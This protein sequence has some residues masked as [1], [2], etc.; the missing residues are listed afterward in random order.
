MSPRRCAL[1][2]VAALCAVAGT[3]GAPAAR[4][5]SKPT[6]CVALVV[7]GRALGS[8]V[9]TGCAKVS[10]GATGVA[11]L[12]AAD[13]RIGFRDDGL[14]CTID[15]LPKTGCASVDDTHYWAYF[16]RAPG[17]TSWTYSTEGAST[18]QPV[19][20]STEGWVYD[21]GTS[22]TPDNVPYSQICKS[23]S[24][25]KPTASPT[26]APHPTT[27]PRPPASR[28]KTATPATAASAVAPAATAHRHHH[29]RQRGGDPRGSS[30]PTTAVPT[31]TPTP[32]ITS[33]ALAG[34]GAAS[35]RHHVGRDVLVV[36]LLV[37]AFGA[38]GVASYRRAH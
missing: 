29:H 11:V 37:A 9:S 23:K 30:G 14:I 1:V 26:P 10:K 36:A 32:T 28:H 22:L 27:T 25:A 15:G 16:H 35:S 17:A 13:H 31:P 8:N 38:A 33:A 18:Y 5:S 7:D 34:T 20:D 21:N 2:L 19:N 12:E 3:F 24:K 6:I 4:A